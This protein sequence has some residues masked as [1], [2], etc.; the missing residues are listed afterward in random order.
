MPVNPRATLLI[1]PGD[2]SDVYQIGKPRFLTA[3]V[4][5]TTAI[6]T[7]VVGDDVT[8][9][10]SVL[11][12]VW[13]DPDDAA[14]LNSR[15]FVA[16]WRYYDSMSPIAIP[17][18]VGS[19]ATY[20]ER[21]QWIQGETQWLGF[22]GSSAGVANAFPEFLV[23]P[24]YNCDRMYFQIRQYV[25]PAG[26]IAWIGSG[27]YGVTPRTPDGVVPAVLGNAMA[28]AMGGGADDTRCD[29]AV[30]TGAAAIALAMPNIGIDFE[31]VSV[32]CHFSAAP[33]LAGAFTVTN[34]VT[35][36]PYDTL[37]YSVDPSVM[38]L[39]DLVYTPK[40]R[41][42]FQAADL[43]TVAYANPSAVTYGARITYRSIFST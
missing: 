17:G 32:A 41:L 34:N 28:F 40:T 33:A 30:A 22:N 11:Y 2:P 24:T 15:V 21:G 6:P 12:S 18:G 3:A 42:L 9:W 10:H 1:K 8:Q 16:V 7:T 23:V 29:I 36:A 43:I 4:G 14:I 5:L 26:N 31:L 25:G 27:L 35:G 39:T 19:A 38:G 37:L 20:T 13:T